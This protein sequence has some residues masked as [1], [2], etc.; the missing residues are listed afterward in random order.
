MA[1]IYKALLSLLPGNPLLVGTVVAASG[2]ELRI[3]LPDGALATARGAYSVGETVAFRPGGAVEGTA[4][5]LPF[6]EIEV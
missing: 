2:D 3:E 4:P 5:A 6:V 1:N